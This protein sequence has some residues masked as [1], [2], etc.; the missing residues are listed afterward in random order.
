M[1]GSASRVAWKAL[2]R[3]IARMA[4][5]FSTGKSSTLATCW[6][7]ALLTRMS[8][9]PKRSAAKAIMASISAGLL[10]SAP[11]YS[12]LTPS[13]AISAFGPSM[14]PKPFST[15]LAPCCASALAMPRPMPLVDPVTSAVLFESMCELQFHYDR[16][17]DTGIIIVDA[18]AHFL[19]M[20]APSLR[21]LSVGDPV[22][23]GGAARRMAYWDWPSQDAQPKHTVICVHGLS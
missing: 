18:C 23:V 21:F 1:A 22:A 7:P 4:S 2:D 16:L 14:S 15:M 8:T 3:L 5:H 12:T 9:R 19:T 20:L 13:P 17:K 11:W 6:M 10:M